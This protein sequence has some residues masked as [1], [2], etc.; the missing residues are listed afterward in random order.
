MKPE[1]AGGRNNETSGAGFFG[2]EVK[3][4]DIPFHSPKKPALSRAEG[5]TEEKDRPKRRE[6]NLSELKKALEESLENKEEEETEKPEDKLAEKIEEEKQMDGVLK[7]ENKTNEENNKKGIIK[8][9]ET[10]NF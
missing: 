9:G 1:A 2:Q 10:V 3:I 5:R 7:E 4:Q 8:P 6:I